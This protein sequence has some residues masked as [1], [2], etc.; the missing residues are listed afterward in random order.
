MSYYADSAASC[1]PASAPTSTLPRAVFAAPAA[2]AAF[3]E[4]DD[5][6]ADTSAE[7]AAVPSPAFSAFTSITSASAAAAKAYPPPQ[8]F[9]RGSTQP[10]AA[11]PPQSYPA[12]A[13]FQPAASAATAKQ[14]RPPAD[15]G[16]LLAANGPERRPTS[17][18]PDAVVLAVDDRDDMAPTRARRDSASASYSAVAEAYPAARGPTRRKASGAASERRV[19]PRVV[20]REVRLEGEGNFVVELPVA[21]RLLKDVPFKDHEEFTHL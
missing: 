19:T 3:A 5:A 13:A 1:T 9:G 8:N 15:S 17:L 6:A 20:R 10:S 12:P 2:V 21:K 4:P 18:P 7:T 11:A 14:S 16:F